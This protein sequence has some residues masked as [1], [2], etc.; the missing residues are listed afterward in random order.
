MS[1][2]SKPSVG[3]EDILPLFM[4]CLRK[5]QRVNY[6]KNSRPI[7][8]NKLVGLKVIIGQI[9]ENQIYK[10][11]GVCM[12]IKSVLQILLDTRQVL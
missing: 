12:K 8:L 4:V 10:A 3:V 6:G 1:F 7:Y 2:V 5:Q 9:V 11:I